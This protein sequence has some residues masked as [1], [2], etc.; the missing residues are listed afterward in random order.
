MSETQL[1]ELFAIPINTKVAATLD[2]MPL[3]S[4]TGLKKRYLQA[5]AKSG[6]TK[7]VYST[8]AKL[9]E[10]DLLI[11]CFLSK[12]L[13]NLA[14]FKVFAPSGYKAIHGFYATDVKKIFLFIDNTISYGF[15]S[16]NHLARLTIH[17]GVHMA[18]KKGNFINTFKTELIKYYRILFDRM[19]RDF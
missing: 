3:Y 6:R 2:G 10:K 14:K 1:Q 13:Y 11:P 4:S 16:N 7:P 18:A 17:E 19:F 15:A 12:N 8:I 9:V 5:M